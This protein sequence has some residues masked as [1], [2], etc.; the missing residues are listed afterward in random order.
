MRS[1]EIPFPTL[2]GGGGTTVNLRK[3]LGGN[4]FDASDWVKWYGIP[5]EACAGAPPFPWGLEFLHAT[6]PFF[7]KWKVRQTHFAF[8]GMSA[9]GGE[10]LTLLR[11]EKFHP[12]GRKPRF[13][14]GVTPWYG[15]EVFTWRTLEFRW[16]FLLKRVVPGSLN[17]SYAAQ[18]ALL[19]SGYEPPLALEEAM[20][21]IFFYWK[22][23]F[24]RYL[25]SDCL[26]RCRDRTADGAVVEV[27]NF[28][29]AG[30]SISHSAPD[31]PS[32]DSGIGASCKCP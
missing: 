6:C 23:S 1:I 14:S 16:Y 11:F 20:K 21:D 19:P 12:P 29:K 25:N 18:T 3:I 27:G 2:A 13:D 24:W 9:V 8:L 30:L 7:P 31:E 5:A 26:A 32:P 17:L 28:D 15:L 22:H 4:L 10:S